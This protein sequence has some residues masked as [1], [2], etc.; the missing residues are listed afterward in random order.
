M[1]D[2]SSLFKTISL[3]AGSLLAIT[4]GILA[5]LLANRS[6]IGIAGA[7]FAIVLIITVAGLMIWRRETASTY[8]ELAENAALERLRNVI[9]T[10]RAR[11]EHWNVEIDV[12]LSIT[13]KQEGQS[14]SGGAS[15]TRSAFIASL[16]SQSHC[17][18][19]TGMAGSGK[20]ALLAHIALQMIDARTAG[21]SR[22]TPLLLEG[23][24]WS[25][26]DNWSTWVTNQTKYYY[27]IESHV[28][29]RWLN[30]GSIVLIIDG[31]DEISDR[32]RQSFV[33]Q[34]NG[35]LKSAVGGRVIVAC[36]TD[37]YRQN[38]KD[39]IHDQVA[40][41]EP[42]P[43]REIEGYLRRIL[44]RRSID[45]RMR[46][47]A[48]SLLTHVIE[49]DPELSSR[50]STPLLVRLLADGVIDMSFSPYI[51]AGLGETKDPAALAVG[52][53][54]RLHQQ[55]NDRGAI[56]SYI[57]GINSPASQW[58]SIAGVRASLLLARSGEFDRARETLI[59]TLATEIEQSYH[60]SL[61]A[62]EKDLTS[63]EKAV[64]KVLSTD[65]T[66]DAFQVSSLSSIPPNRCNEA[67]RSLRDRSLIEVV[68]PEKK[69][70]RFR[71]LSLEL[72]EL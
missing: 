10:R 14:L 39:I 8:I 69:E 50:W 3:V 46:V 17:T 4:V 30:Q 41:L 53:G 70:P 11:F 5:N 13:S 48:R 37:S 12:H 38:F 2:K 40:N 42:L 60:E 45:D 63:D 1:T 71:R 43:Y 25:Y 44:D 64:L 16:T 26:E 15:T 61:T 65:I 20:S 27:G 34:L 56:E 35:W 54:D 58:R 24:G 68:D 31:L 62:F 66:L 47:D 9:A 72:A 49:H 6:E 67:L 52:L 21:T 55:G 22:F 36:R 29:H 32:E 28:T 51:D 18:V 23:R 7:T 59:S 19:V 57:A 33:P